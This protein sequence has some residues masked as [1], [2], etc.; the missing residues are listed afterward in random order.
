MQQFE[1]IDYTRFIPLGQTISYHV[2]VTF[3]NGQTFVRENLLWVRY[4]DDIDDLQYPSSGSGSGGSVDPLENVA[5]GSGTDQ[6]L[7]F[8]QLQDDLESDDL[9]IAT[10]G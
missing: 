8:I 4:A 3:S 2:T 5:S 7:Q 6:D 10:K 1:Y 9:F